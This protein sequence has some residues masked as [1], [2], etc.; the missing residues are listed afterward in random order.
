M[1]NLTDGEASG[2]GSVLLRGIEKREHL[3][4]IHQTSGM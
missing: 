1:L 4:Y 2:S 3:Q